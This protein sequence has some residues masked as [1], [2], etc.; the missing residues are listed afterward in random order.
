[1]NI[2]ELTRYVKVTP[3]LAEQMAATQRLLDTLPSQDQMVDRTWF[4]K[5]ATQLDALAV[6]IHQADGVVTSFFSEASS[7]GARFCADDSGLA[8]EMRRAIDYLRSLSQEAEQ[9]TSAYSNEQAVKASQHLAALLIALTTSLIETTLA[10]LG[11]LAK[12]DPGR[13]VA[14]LNYVGQVIDTVKG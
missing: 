13:F 6:S 10:D 9:Y 2:D 8:R 11:A 12:A 4:T 5:C 1:M 14:T 3:E 7:N